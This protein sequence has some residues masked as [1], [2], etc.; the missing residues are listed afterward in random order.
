MVNFYLEENHFVFELDNENNDLQ[1]FYT[2]EYFDFLGIE[3]EILSN[4]IP[5]MNG[6]GYFQEGSELTIPYKYF[7][8]FIDGNMSSTKGQDQES[9]QIEA[10]RSYTVEEPELPTDNNENSI[11]SD[12]ISDDDN[13]IEESVEE[14][15]EIEESIEIEEPKEIDNSIEDVIENVIEV[16]PSREDLFDEPTVDSVENPTDED[17]MQ[18]NVVSVKNVLILKIEIDD[19]NTTFNGALRDIMISNKDENEDNIQLNA[20]GLFYE[21]IERIYI[22]KNYLNTDVYQEEV[23]R[24]NGKFIVIKENSNESVD[25]ISDLDVSMMNNT[26][27]TNKLRK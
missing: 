24:I 26:V 23:F 9:N 21:D 7:A 22:I 11:N 5:K 16:G 13:S 15:K 18:E 2:P 4:N 1:R 6:G 3:I 27:L 10:D 25:N 19:E 20:D 14:P 12:D 17:V 8:N